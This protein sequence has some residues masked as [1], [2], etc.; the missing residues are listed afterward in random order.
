MGRVKYSVKEIGRTEEV[1]LPPSSQEEPQSAN[2]I[3]TNVPVDKFEE[4]ENVIALV[5][6]K[7]VIAKTEEEG[8]EVKCKFC[9]VSDCS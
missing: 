2:S 9:W 8:D 3:T 4:F 1:K 6:E 5:S 7:E